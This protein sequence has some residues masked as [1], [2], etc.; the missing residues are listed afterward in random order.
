[1]VITNEIKALIPKAPFFPIVTVSAQKEPHLIVAGQVKEV[2]DGDVLAFGI[3]KMQTTQRNIQET[4]QMQVVIV[5]RE[6][7]P[8]GFR[9]L[10]N[11]CVEGQLVL[12]RA[13]KAE[14]LL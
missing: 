1:M 14:A 12:F 8:K 2:R 4:G 7:G 5:T 11:A 6:G 9:L 3:Y 10:G 13:E